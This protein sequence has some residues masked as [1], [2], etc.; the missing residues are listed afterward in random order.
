MIDLRGIKN[1]IF[2]YG[3]VIINIDFAL[4]INTF[5]K[6]G[7]KEIE[8]ILFQTDSSDLLQ[9]IEK[10]LISPPEFYHKIREITGLDINDNTIRDAWNA[11]LLDMPQKRIELLE[12]LRTRYRIFLLSNSNIIHYH[13][14]QEELK[15][16]YGYSDFN[17]LFEKAWFSF[18][19]HMIKPDKE[20]FQFVINDALLCPDETLF[21]D[22]SEINIKGGQLAGLRTHHLLNEEIVDIL[23]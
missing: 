5:K 15:N 4:T 8:K 22:D 20:I 9:Q 10:G 18:N 16:K 11:L 23:K 12:K 7:A 3:G 17:S 1:I 2:D 21:I 14:Y 19:L 13:Y 6:L